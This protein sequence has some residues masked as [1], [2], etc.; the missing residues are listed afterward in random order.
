MG[1]QYS[2]P[3]AGP[4]VGGHPDGRRTG[5]RR[6]L[7]AAMAALLA[8]GLLLGWNSPPS[9]A[10][11]SPDGWSGQGRATLPSGLTVRLDLAA[12][13][14]VTATAEPGRLADRPGVGRPAGY[15]DGLT[16]GAPAEAFALAP[17]R[18]RADGSWST[19]GTLQISFSR[20]VRN[21][22]LHVSGLAA[23]ATGQGGST[24]TAARLTVTGGSPAAPVLT[25]RTSWTGWTVAGNTLAP[26][27]PDGGSDASPDAAAEGSLELAGTFST[28]T[29]RIEQRSTARA[30]SGTPPAALRQ[31]YTVTLDEAVGTAPA[32]YTNASHLVT[33]L[34]LGTDAGLGP[35]RTVR[36]AGGG[37]TTGGPLVE[38]DHGAARR[39][40][41]AGV[42]AP[43][44]E[45]A[46]GE[47]QGAD[48]AVRYPAEASIGHYYRLSV[49][50]AVGGASAT[51]AGW[52][53]FDRNGRFDAT[54]RVQAEARAGATTADLEWTVP[55]GAS[56]G[57]TWARLRLAREAS[58]LVA[59][60]G[61]ADS[62]GV[63]DQRVR[64]AVG[65][66]RP[67]ISRPVDGSTVADA[68]P[69]VR[70]EGA[71]VGAAVEI[72]EGGSA[73]CRATVDRAGG[74]ACRPAAALA[75]GAHGLTPVE[76]TIGGVVLTGDPVRFT[77]KS[78]PPAAPVLALPEFT[79]D[80]GLLLTGTGEPGSTVSVADQA[81]AAA[82]ELCSTL[83]GPGG[84]WSCLPVENLPDG[85]HRLT[86]SAVDAAGNRVSG[87]ATPLIVDTVAPA[88][89]V[90]TSP[91]AGET[92]R[93]ARPRFAGRAEGGSTVM[94]G[95]RAVAPAS[96]ERVPACS[97]VA[98]VDGGWSCT[99]ARDLAPGDHSTFVSATDRAGNGTT[100]NAVTIRLAAPVAAPSA[101]ATGSAAGVPSATGAA[102]AT[103]TATVSATATSAAT[104][105]PAVRPSPS[106][107]PSRSPVASAVSGAASASSPVPVKASTAAAASS[108]QPSPSSVPSP[109]PSSHPSSQPSAPPASPAPTATSMPGR[110]SA[111]P[112]APGASAAATAGLSPIA[113][114]AEVETA[115][116]PA[117]PGLLP[118]VVPPAAVPAL[119]SV[120]PSAASATA[121]ATS[122]PSAS[123]SPSPSVRPSAQP[124]VA[125]PGGTETVPPLP[126][127]SAAHSAAPSGPVS[128]PPPS[129]ALSPSAAASSTVRGSA[130]PLPPAG[131][132]A[133]RLSGSGGDGAA[134]GEEAAD[135][136]A[137]PGGP[138]VGGAVA[139]HRPVSTGWRAALAGALLL[140]ASVGLI[141]RRVFW[142]G[143]GRR[144]R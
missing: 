56:A 34:L 81:G 91:A 33:D 20:P 100:A 31:A 5:R 130:Q 66:A 8:A 121:S 52:V 75:Q 88:A 1:R 144:R 76:T 93:T 30:G 114:P 3:A 17:D 44:P 141:T 142:R 87:R 43:R 123:P 137:E 42:G 16:A 10:Q 55:P 99:A 86:P 68:R 79:N 67:E 128:M 131:S 132:S 39:S 120:L 108:A 115:L 97:A 133:V 122:R 29:L 41:F 109:H 9:L 139:Q 59:P 46:R 117:P 51:L 62:G 19:L 90:L 27:G 136:A 6:A 119:P 45:P 7:G 21:P 103:G 49:P 110:P 73:L 104:G 113:V 98:A 84:S 65:A 94:V 74:W 38:L 83:V 112:G 116:P 15:A 12:A 14:G 124:V 4:T 96:A 23:L 40:A 24:A 50:V 134:A 63:E 89:P 26:A 48:P 53:D 28:A 72:R 57:E 135:P 60:G 92:L 107:T 35:A 18:P 70:G 111:G 64:L 61:F 54:E 106:P 32:G 22:R 102:N 95:T 138:S 36:P 129:L 71:V 143:S 80:P 2:H 101:S 47:Y 82:V 126:T 85:T 58:Q 13:P 11:Q 140:L 127:P 105:V 25:A 69:E 125:S 77:V 78:A 37:A 118:I